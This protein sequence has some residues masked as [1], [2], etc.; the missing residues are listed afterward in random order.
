VARRWFSIA[1]GIALAAFVTAGGIPTLRHD[2]NW[3]IDRIAVGSFLSDSTSGW[4]SVGFGVANP[5]PTTYLIG[6]PLAAVMWLFGP[7]AGLALLAFL[8]GFCCARGAVHLAALWGATTPASIGIA[9][10]LSF[11][12]WVY[13]EIVAGHLVMVLAYGAFAGMLAE[14][15]RGGAA[16]PVRLAL[17][18]VL[19]E[20]QLQFFIVA[21]AVAAIFAIVTKKWLPLGAGALVALPS[22]VGLLGERGALLQIP[23]GVE[24]QANQSIAPLALLSL[25]GY[26]AGYA[27]RLGLAA[28]IAVFAILALAIAGTVVAWRRRAALWTALGAIVVYLVTSGVHG[29]LAV[30]YE[31]IVRNVPES[32]VFRELYD[33][34]GI[35]AVSMAMLAAAC[36]SRSRY[37]GFAAL[38]AGIA[39]A[40]TWIVRP[41][42]ELWVSSNDYPHPSVAA[43]PFTRVALLPSFQ[44]MQLRSGRGDGADPDSFIYPGD[45]APVNEYYPTY[46]VDMALA[47]YEQTGD[48]RGLQALGVGAIVDRPW[49]ASRSQGAIG[50]AASS[51]APPARSAQRPSG[52]LPGA[53]PI[54]AGCDR[55]RVVA[56][57]ENLGTCD[58]F[59]GDAS[60]GRTVTPVEARSDSIDPASS[61]IDAPLAF[62]RAPWLAQGLGGAVTQSTAAHPVKPS[63]WLLAYV[64]GRL[65]GT[66]GRTLASDAGTY[67]WIAIPSGTTGVV[68]SGLCA[69]AAESSAPPPSAGTPAAGRPVP[70][71]FEELT[72]WLYRVR[73]IAPGTS[74][75]RFNERYDPGWLAIG[76]GHLLTHLRVALYANGWLA[77]E[78]PVN[79]AILVQITALLQLIAE[80]AGA[81]CVLLLLKALV[82]EPTK[83]A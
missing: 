28:E 82:R 29:P 36:A 31:W 43:A 71:A 39:L 65:S 24:W 44:P 8:T 74:L 13:N 66:D 56:T 81:A 73:G 67:R 14:M 3:P 32:G 25:G 4:L 23:Y 15:A 69:L 46:P 59:F 57:V 11:N 6:P 42:S 72:P 47:S 19:I 16:S 52:P 30:P 79:A 50:L 33:L 49:L 22:I 17:W 18:L 38:A 12:P 26:F 53:A 64:R 63:S 78:E 7:L 1:A 70:L 58:V 76:A 55:M 80:L 41:P 21:M 34:A 5:H 20:S 83:R 54:V 75:V 35:F 61:W 37:L 60:G 62:G 48:V 2:W 45:V 68:C 51:L 40:V 9:L 10:F 27:D 77:S